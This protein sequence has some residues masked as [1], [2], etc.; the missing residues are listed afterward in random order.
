MFPFFAPFSTY[1]GK[2]PLSGD[3]LQA[4][5]PWTWNLP[6]SNWGLFNIILGNPGSSKAESEIL[7]EV[8]S[9]GR[10]IG[11]LADAVDVLLATLDMKQLTDQ[12]AAAVYAFKEQI[13][14]VRALKG[15]TT[16]RAYSD[17]SYP[18]VTPKPSQPVTQQPS[19]PATPHS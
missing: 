18:P 8:G 13:A 12:Q 6:Y 4:I 3:V 7:N 19:P 11:R 17:L 14:A 1:A 2:A 5:N 15:R 10:Q 9:Y 16:N